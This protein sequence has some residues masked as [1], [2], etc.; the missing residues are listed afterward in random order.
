MAFPVFLFAPNASIP[1]YQASLERLKALSPAYDTV[2]PCHERFP[3][4]P[5]PALEALPDCARQA[6][7]GD[8]QKLVTFDLDMS[9]TVARFSGYGRTASPWPPGSWGR[10]RPRSEPSNY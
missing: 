4:T 7:E 3:L 1:D 9:V 6:L 5:G 10:Y 2:Y 8:P